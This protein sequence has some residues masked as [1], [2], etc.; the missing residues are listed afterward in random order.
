MCNFVQPGTSIP[1]V[2]TFTHNYKGD[3]T[4]IP[5]CVVDFNFYFLFSQ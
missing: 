2:C 5:I 3:D 4:P 1:V